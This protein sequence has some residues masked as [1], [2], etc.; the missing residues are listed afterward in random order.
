MEVFLPLEWM[1]SVNPRWINQVDQSISIGQ[2]NNRCIEENCL[3]ENTDFH[4][5][6]PTII[7]VL[8]GPQ[9]VTSFPKS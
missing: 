6:A 2:Q 3:N 9:T 4:K 1:K 7:V 8:A 5:G